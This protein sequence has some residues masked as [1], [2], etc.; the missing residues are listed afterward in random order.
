MP[1]ATFATDA[2]TAAI[3]VGALGTGFG[4]VLAALE[5]RLNSKAKRAETDTELSRL[6]TELVPIANG[7][8]VTTL[9]DAVATS[10]I[11]HGLITRDD[12]RAGVA[13]AHLSN[14]AISLPIGAATMAAALRSIAELGTRHDVLKEPARSAVQAM[15]YLENTAGTREA[16]SEA[17]KALG[18]N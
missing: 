11:E 5:Y 1:I 4:V 6:F 13:G 3:I 2:Q 17:S 10:L 18:L 15:S 16:Y 14:A 9:P 12:V 7:Y 8:S